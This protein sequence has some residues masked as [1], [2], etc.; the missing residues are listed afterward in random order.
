MSDLKLATARYKGFDWKWGHPVL[1]TVGKPRVGRILQEGTIVNAI[2]PYGVFNVR[3]PLSPPEFKARYLERLDGKADEIDST[4]ST[5]ASAHP[6]ETLVILCWCEVTDRATSE[7][8][9]HQFAGWA[10]N[11]YGILVPDLDLNRRS[12]APSQ[13]SL[14]V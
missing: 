14:F 9:R 5:L 6:G 7:C 8:H 3:P 4:L 2:A 13:P 11:R 1:T 12:G 10:E